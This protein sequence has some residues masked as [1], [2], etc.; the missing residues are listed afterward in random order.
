VRV[1]PDGEDDGK[2]E[3]GGESF[4]RLGMRMRN[5]MLIFCHPPDTIYVR[6]GEQPNK[7]G[8]AKGGGHPPQ[9]D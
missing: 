3:D 4:T 1:S 7:G 2:V 5:V 9:H 8:T 6:F